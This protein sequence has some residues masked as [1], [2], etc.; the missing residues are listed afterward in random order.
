M[1][2][3]DMK[4]MYIIPTAKAISLNAESLIATSF[5]VDNTEENAITGNGDDQ[6]WTNRGNSIWDN[7]TD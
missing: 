5:K 7:W 4:K 3:T 6:A 1:E 2:D